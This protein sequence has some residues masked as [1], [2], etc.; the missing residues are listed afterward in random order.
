MYDY[1]RAPKLYYI[2]LY[3]VIYILQY[4]NITIFSNITLQNNFTQT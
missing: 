3:V 1:I 4:I 2:T